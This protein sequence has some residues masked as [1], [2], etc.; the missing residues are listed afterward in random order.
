MRAVDGISFD[1]KKGETLG[2]VGESGC[3][4]STAA[5]LLI[6]LIE[7]D[8]GTVIFDGEPVDVGRRTAQRARTSAA[9]SRWCFR[10]QL[11]L[12]QPATDHRRLDHVR[13]QGQS[14]FTRADDESAPARILGMVGSGAGHVRSALSARAFGRSAPAREHCA[15]VGAWVRA[16]LILDEAVSAL[17]KSVEAQ[18]LNLLQ[19]LKASACSLRTSSSRMISMSCSTSAIACW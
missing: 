2:I 15:C 5:R 6:H 18:V 14:A 10:I 17:D 19:D 3:G 13:A 7:P 9:R 12:A 4:K 8:A 1:V 11:R 16:L